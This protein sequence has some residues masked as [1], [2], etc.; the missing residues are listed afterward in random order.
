MKLKTLRIGYTSLSITLYVGV[1]LTLTW[2]LNGNV[3][4]MKFAEELG[5]VLFIATLAAW[6]CH[7]LVETDLR[8]GRALNG[9]L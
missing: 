8:A 9:K 4:W 5:W 6:R 1:A 7:E 3:T 2:L